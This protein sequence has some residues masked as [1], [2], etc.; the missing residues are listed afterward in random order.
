MTCCKSLT[1]MWVNLIVYIEGQNIFQGTNREF[2][3][4]GE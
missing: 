1:N 4:S 2:K 3:I